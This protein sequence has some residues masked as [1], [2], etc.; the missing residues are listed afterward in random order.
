M[1]SL[2]LTT[3]SS[4]SSSSL[5]E[6]ASCVMGS[7][8]SVWPFS[9]SRAARMRAAGEGRPSGLNASSA[10]AATS[11]FRY[12]WTGKANASSA[13]ASTSSAVVVFGGGCDLDRLGVDEVNAP[14]ESSSMVG[15]RDDMSSSSDALVNSNLV[16]DVDGNLTNGSGSLVSGIDCGV[17]VGVVFIGL[18]RLMGSTG[19]VDV[20]GGWY[21]GRVGGDARGATFG[22]DA[23]VGIGCVAV[24]PEYIYHQQSPQKHI[25]L[26]SVFPI[27]SKYSQ[28]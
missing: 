26:E 4:C 18:P 7:T 6:G 15:N 28:P 13:N 25:H 22:S 10:K 12:G 21:T 8:H 14:P 5:D 11:F 17:G 24:G 2:G 23:A 1:T 9:R 19:R 3:R 16:T 20:T 27:L